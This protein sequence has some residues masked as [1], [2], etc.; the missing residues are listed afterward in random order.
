MFISRM[1]QVDMSIM[2]YRCQIGNSDS[3]KVDGEA[4]FKEI[5]S[6][7]SGTYEN[8]SSYASQHGSALF[9][10]SCGLIPSMENNIQVLRCRFENMNEEARRCQRDSRR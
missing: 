2:I 1:D 3:F 7:L 4:R 10:A 9:S 6:A 8:T 5:R